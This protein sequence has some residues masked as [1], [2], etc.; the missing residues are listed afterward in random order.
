MAIYTTDRVKRKNGDRIVACKNGFKAVGLSAFE[1]YKQ[2][3]I[4]HM[5]FKMALEDRR[6]EQTEDYEA[7]KERDELTAIAVKRYSWAWNYPKIALQQ[8]WEESVDENSVDA[9]RLRLFPLGTPKNVQSAQMALDAFSHFNAA[10][11]REEV[12]LYPPKF[13]EA[14]Q[15]LE[16]DLIAAM[17][18]VT[19]EGNETTKATVK[20]QEAR[21]EWDNYYKSLKDITRGYLRVENR[22]DELKPLFRSPSQ[23]KAPA[24]TVE[25]H[26]SSEEDSNSQ[27]QT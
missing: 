19:R 9:V 20:H 22:L 24:E 18:K 16:T 26:I 8:S 2:F 12:L 17:D 14:T 4:V 13:I 10:Q 1:F 21:T 6:R 23:G 11:A 15:E 7:R 5:A 25:E 3:C 27:P